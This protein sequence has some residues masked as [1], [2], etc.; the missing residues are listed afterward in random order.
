M[1]YNDFKNILFTNLG[2]MYIITYCLCIFG[3]KFWRKKFSKKSRPKV[4]FETCTPGRPSP[5]I[6]GDAT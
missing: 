5:K 4:R 1:A 2:T 3:I 6:L